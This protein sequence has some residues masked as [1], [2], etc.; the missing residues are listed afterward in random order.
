MESRCVL[1]CWKPEGRL[2]NGNVNEN[3]PALHVTIAGLNVDNDTEIL[4]VFVLDTY[5]GGNQ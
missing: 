2:G 4:Q 5:A 3:H 1:E